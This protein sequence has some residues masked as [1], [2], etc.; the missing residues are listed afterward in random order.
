MPE[1]ATGRPY[2]LRGASFNLSE[3]PA[4]Q[5]WGGLH[6]KVHVPEGLNGSSSIM[7]KVGGRVQGGLLC[8]CRLPWNYCT[9]M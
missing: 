7:G 5:T 8:Y 9:C 1:L 4:S 3:A 6:D 2:D